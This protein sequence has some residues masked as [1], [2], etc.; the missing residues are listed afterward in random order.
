MTLFYD[1]NWIIVLNGNGDGDIDPAKGAT[2]A[3]R[4]VHVYYELH[5]ANLIYEMVITV[6]A[7]VTHPNVD[8]TKMVPKVLVRF[9]S[10][11]KIRRYVWV[12]W[13][14]LGSRYV[15]DGC[16]R[17]DRIPIEILSNPA[18]DATPYKAN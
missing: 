2:N 9:A 7:H 12:E 3:L 1:L 14:D 8:V 13:Y 6:R 16:V 10:V 11:F 15:Y 4:P 17:S 5:P 18:V